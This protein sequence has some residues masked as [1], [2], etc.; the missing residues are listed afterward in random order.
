MFC[1]D[2]CGPGINASGRGRVFEQSRLSGGIPQ[3]P[4]QTWQMG[5]LDQMGQ[6]G[7]LG[8][9]DQVQQNQMPGR[10]CL[11][12]HPHCTMSCVPVPAP[13]FWLSSDQ[14]QPRFGM[15]FVTERPE[16]LR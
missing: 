6:M 10:V 13:N 4:N 14:E 1:T 12:P 2:S 16:G 15:C 9:T 11:P 5:Q 8:Q 7:P 3:E